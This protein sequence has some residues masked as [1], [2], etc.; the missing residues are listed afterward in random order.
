MKE[1]VWPINQENSLIP[2]FPKGSS[3]PTTTLNHVMN[4]KS[5]HI[6]GVNL[7][8]VGYFGLHFFC[9]K[10][11]VK[12]VK[13]VFESVPAASSAE[14]SATKTVSFSELLCVLVGACLKPW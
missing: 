6:G 11:K 13:S 9:R 1:V 12:E 8:H 3:G 4:G 10:I 14:F 7:G 5:F 2:S